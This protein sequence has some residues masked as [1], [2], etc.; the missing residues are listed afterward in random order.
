M[1]KTLRDALFNAVP[2]TLRVPEEK[3]P[4]AAPESVIWIVLAVQAFV[5]VCAFVGL[6][7]WSLLYTFTVTTTV[8]DVVKSTP[9]TCNVLSP[10]DSLVPFDATISEGAHYSTATETTTSCI[11]RLQKVSNNCDPYKM[12]FGVLS[13]F[14]YSTSTSMCYAFFRDGTALCTDAAVQPLTFNT[15]HGGIPFRPP[16][17][18]QRSF[19]NFASFP[20]QPPG[21]YFRQFA[22]SGAP[23]VDAG[24]DFTTSISTSFLQSAGF[25]PVADSAGQNIYYVSSSV[26]PSSNVLVWQFHRIAASNPQAKPEVVQAFGGV[27]PINAACGMMATA[28]YFYFGVALD[29]NGQVMN[30]I[31]Q[32]NVAKRPVVWSDAISLQDIFT[33]INPQ[34]RATDF[35]CRTTTRAMTIG[36]D[37]FG[38]MLMNP[39]TITYPNG[40]VDGAARLIRFD[41]NLPLQPQLVA[42]TSANYWDPLYISL[43]YYNQFGFSTIAK[44]GS[45][46][47]VSGANVVI[48]WNLPA[49]PNPFT[50]ATPAVG[51]QLTAIPAYAS[52]FYTVFG[53]TQQWSMLLTPGYKANT[54]WVMF[55]GHA[56]QYDLSKV[57]FASVE[58]GN[59]VPL[60]NDPY[61]DQ[62]TAP[63]IYKNVSMG[64]GFGLCNGKLYNVTDTN[65]VCLCV[66]YP[67]STHPPATLVPHHPL[68]LS[69]PIFPHPL[70]SPTA[71]LPWATLLLRLVQR[72]Q[73]LL[74]PKQLCDHGRLWVLQVRPVR[75]R[76]LPVARGRRV[77]KRQFKVPVVGQ[78]NV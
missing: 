27:P 16:L 31:Y 37:G 17:P 3:N 61:N 39:T 40:V 47:Y 64:W 66:W 78:S 21:T 13:I 67:L 15:L 22:Q 1:K 9:Y 38:Y 68:S 48:Y 34:P 51:V 24:F 70:P 62:T 42:L 26:E 32:G 19:P 58:K 60:P 6:T 65:L 4:F 14:G 35:L 63:Y 44:I 41:P 20:A 71:G 43:A 2:D 10:R 52:G 75:S 49:L 77:E 29:I 25:A 46:L 72:G 53:N 18:T 76:Q 57:D 11:M 33:N 74:H 56:Y 12:A 28:T 45:R 54:L 5:F 8:S 73:R 55:S 50:D 7:V 59:Q 36:D 23:L 69:H 30:F